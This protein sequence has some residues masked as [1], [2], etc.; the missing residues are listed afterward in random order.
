MIL[1]S[2]ST[3][4]VD[5]LVARYIEF[6]KVISLEIANSTTYI[7]VSNMKYLTMLPKE[8]FMKDYIAIYRFLFLFAISDVNMSQKKPYYLALKLIVF[9]PSNMLYNIEIVVMEQIVLVILYLTNLT[10]NSEI[11]T[12]Y[13]YFFIEMLS[14][15]EIA[16]IISK[17]WVNKSFILCNKVIII[18]L[19]IIIDRIFS[20]KVR[21]DS[22]ICYNVNNK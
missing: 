18:I 19:F 12:S 15:Q 16:R 14:F 21:T 9:I 17:T 5:I 8:V 3:F 11:S 4:T 20:K 1:V 7:Y 2:I 13:C 6:M 22:K 10:L